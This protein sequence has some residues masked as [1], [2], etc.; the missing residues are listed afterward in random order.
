MGGGLQPEKL[1]EF[2]K[3]FDDYKQY[4]NRQRQDVLDLDVVREAYANN[5]VE[6]DI[7][8]EEFDIFFKPFENEKLVNFE[9]F[10]ELISMQE[11]LIL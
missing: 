3:L 6:I 5:K 10:S 11:D 8:K 7:S 4:H 2:R 9:Q 1:T